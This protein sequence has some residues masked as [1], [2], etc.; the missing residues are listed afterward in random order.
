MTKLHH[1][2]VYADRETGEFIN[3]RDW[4][5]LG[6]VDEAWHSQREDT[7]REHFDTHR[8]TPE[9]VKLIPDLDG[10]IGID[11]DDQMQVAIT[12]SHVD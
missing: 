2:K 11:I 8:I 9:F 1:I 7:D 12:Q 4:E 10:E 3:V 6:R 5:Y